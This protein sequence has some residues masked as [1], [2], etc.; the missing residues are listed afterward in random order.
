MA[1]QTQSYLGSRG[2]I[3]LDPEGFPAN[4]PQS[5][6]REQSEQQPAIGLYDG[7]NIL[8]T[9]QGYA[10]FFGISQQVGEDPLIENVFDVFNYQDAAGNYHLIA[11]AESGVYSQRGDL[12]SPAGV[13]SDPDGSGFEVTEAD[14]KGV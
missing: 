11:L 2:F 10:S 8:P 7:A 9:A 1:R 12:G 13:I 6:Q 3:P 14:Y 4:V 5:E